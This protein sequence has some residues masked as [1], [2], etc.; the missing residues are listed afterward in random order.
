M[1]TL[2]T[3]YPE[4]SFEHQ[5]I[6]MKCLS[7][8]DK[9]IQKQVMFTKVLDCCV[10]A[11]VIKSI[12]LYESKSSISSVKSLIIES[13]IFFQTLLMLQYLITK[14]NFQVVFNHLIK[15]LA[16]FSGTAFGEKL[17][18]EVKTAVDKYPFSSDISYF[19]KSSYYL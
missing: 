18:K 6:I 4:K 3:N 14:E 16:D 19:S 11:T 9:T 7:H 5:D 8:Q 17:S 1:T 2:V 13:S 15:K 12:T 10:F